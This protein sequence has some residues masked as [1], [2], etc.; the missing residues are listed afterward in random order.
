MRRNIEGGERPYIPR[1]VKM[2]TVEQMMREFGAGYVS[3]FGD[4]WDFRGNNDGWFSPSRVPQSEDWL[5]ALGYNVYKDGDMEE[6]A[7]QIYCVVTR[8]HLIFYG[9]NWITKQT[10]E[11]RSN[12]GPRPNFLELMEDLDTLYNSSAYGSLRQ[13]FSHYY[14]LARD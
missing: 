13:G 4:V 5:V 12:L 10:V 9:I 7:G 14:C 3:K 8:T 6:I 1:D 2:Y 11:H